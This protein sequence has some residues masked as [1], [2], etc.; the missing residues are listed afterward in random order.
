M[1]EIGELAPSASFAVHTTMGNARSVQE[2]LGKAKLR[3]V[4]TL[5]Y[6]HDGGEE[7]G[8]DLNAVVLAAKSLRSGLKIPGPST[9][10]WRPSGMVKFS[11]CSN[12][13]SLI[14]LFVCRPIHGARSS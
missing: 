1:Y 8:L 7:D 9:K 5:V 11:V 10:T 14:M 6:A 2:V 12:T 4:Q 13:N 3:Y